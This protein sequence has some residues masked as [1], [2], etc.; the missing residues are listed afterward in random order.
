MKLMTAFG[1]AAGGASKTIQEGLDRDETRKARIARAAQAQNAINAEFKLYS[2]KREDEINDKLQDLIGSYRGMEL[3]DPQIAGLIQGGDKTLEEVR[4]YYDA[5]TDAGQNFSSLLNTVYGDGLTAE[6]F[7]EKDFNNATQGY[8]GARIGS[9]RTPY[10]SPIRVEYSQQLKD[11]YK[12]SKMPTDFDEAI[13]T[14]LN[15]KNIIASRIGTA[16]EQPTDKEQMKKLTEH[17]KNIHKSKNEVD[18]VN[19]PPT[20]KAADANSIRATFIASK[21]DAFM[22]FAQM[23]A[24]GIIT[25]SLEGNFNKAMS[26][27]ENLI[28]SENNYLQTYNPLFGNIPFTEFNVDR[29]NEAARSLGRFVHND[30]KSRLQSRLTNTQSKGN[31]TSA[32]IKQA[33]EEGELKRG[34]VFTFT[35]DDGTK[36]RMILR[37]PDDTKRFGYNAWDAQSIQTIQAPMLIRVKPGSDGTT[38]EMYHAGN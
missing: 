17:I 35:K 1:L 5:A 6:S 16:N 8:L 32:T 36:S 2:Q 19:P 13:M 15:L 7:T 18:G 22:T 37:G 9:K 12:A 24:T 3:S 23:D 25:T 29:Y 34:D 4:K 28:V 14:T 38:Y 11:I 31:F 21:K 10:A 30:Y 20:F 26:A 33:M 27:F